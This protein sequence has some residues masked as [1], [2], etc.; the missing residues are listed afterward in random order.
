[1][2]S[3][4]WR[5]CCRA[6]W[7]LCCFH[8]EYAM[9]WCNLKVNL[10]VFLPNCCSLRCCKK[11]GAQK[12]RV[13]R[14]LQPRRGPKRREVAIGSNFWARALTF[15]L[16]PPVVQHLT[17]CITTFWEEKNLYYQPHRR[18]QRG[19]GGAHHLMI[20]FCYVNHGSLVFDWKSI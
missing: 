13:E 14:Q 10:L 20:F 17:Y 15:F 11:N 18:R 9:Y 12:K 1:M 16:H 19:Q 8:S 2:D 3:N 4:L 6:S 7:Y 5:K